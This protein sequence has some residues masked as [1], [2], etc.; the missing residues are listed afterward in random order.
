MDIFP[1]MAHTTEVVGEF[2]RYLCLT[3]VAAGRGVS[4]VEF[5]IGLACPEEDSSLEPI[6]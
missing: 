4:R 5:V 6:Y 2:Q 1:E 3:H